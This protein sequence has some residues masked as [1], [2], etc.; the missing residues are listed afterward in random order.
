MLTKM[1]R[2]YFFVAVLITLTIVTKASDDNWNVDQNRLQV[3]RNRRTFR[4][5][6]Y[7]I[8][9]AHQSDYGLRI[10]RNSPVTNKNYYR[11]LDTD[12]PSSPY[13]HNNPVIISAPV[14]KI[15]KSLENPATF[16]KNKNLFNTTWKSYKPR[17]SIN[18]NGYKSVTRNNRM[19]RPNDSLKLNSPQ[20][21]YP[22]S[23]SMSVDIKGTTLKIHPKSVTKEITYT[24]GGSSDSI[25][26]YKSRSET[27]NLRDKCI[28]CPGERTSIAS[29]G[30]ERI[31]LE[32]P[33]L[34]GCH[35]NP[36]S[37]GAHFKALY[38]PNIGTLLKEGSHIT[39]GSIVVNNQTQQLCQYRYNV[40]V[41]R[42]PELNLSSG[43]ESICPRGGAWGSVCRFKC[44]GPG[45]AP[46]L[47]GPMRIKCKDNL[48][49]SSSPPTC[50]ASIKASDT[51]CK[52][53]PTPH[54]S[55]LNCETKPED[56][57]TGG[58]S[59]DF[60]QQITKDN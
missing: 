3:L 25:S 14:R 2:S 17:L 39:V 48:N 31:I 15:Y 7:P 32:A 30:R 22:K 55:R 10:I 6:K 43:V 16:Y 27:N 60:G 42:C 5:S 51:W 28:R 8:E 56:A 35:G 54:Y 59:E 38:G 9:S 57:P 26:G 34:I 13:S 20:R 46:R 4:E 49:W 12:D 37:E 11:N 23:E 44:S 36:V 21:R 53:P 29:K 33:A 45:L 47:N 18:S 58:L 52:M 1:E 19:Y 24:Y 50:E 40:I 41:R